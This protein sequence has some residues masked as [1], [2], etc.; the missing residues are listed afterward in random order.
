MATLAADNPRVFESGHDNGLNAL[1]VVASDIIYDGAAVGMSSGNA[2]PL[3]AGDDFAG[4]CV[5]QADNSSGSAG[6][7]NVDL[8]QTGVVKLAVTG[9]TAKTDVG[10]D[11]YASD[12]N[13]FTLTASG[14]SSIGTIVRYISSTTVMVK[15]EAVSNRSI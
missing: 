8:Y 15:F 4:F 11:V 6:D 1:P 7:I 5:K 9:V 13:T 3:T 2:R 10:S 14:N 12:D